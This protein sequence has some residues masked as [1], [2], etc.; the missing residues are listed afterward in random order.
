MKNNKGFSIIFLVIIIIVVA[1]VVVLGFYYRSRIV[2]P[3]YSISETLTDGNSSQNVAS[4][5]VNADTVNSVNTSKTNTTEPVGVMRTFK[6]SFK[7]GYEGHYIIVSYQFAYSS[8]KYSVSTG[9]GNTKIIINDKKTGKSNSI[10]IFNNG[11][12]GYASSR[13]I[14]QNFP[15]VAQ[16]CP[17]CVVV[18]Y[19][20]PAKGASGMFIASS[21]DKEVIIY[22]HA[23]GFVIA[24]F[25]K[26]A[27]DLE[28]ILQ[29]L[30]IQI[31]PVAY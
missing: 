25:N 7:S 3:Q 11:A 2:S 5:S 9:N 8:S 29:T 16:F 15:G 30:T 26:P 23:P 10:D 4:S 19:T 27:L 21:P 31:A 20:V 18:D 6:S 1:S 17:S 14:W 28:K 12:A 24:K 22:G 13:Q